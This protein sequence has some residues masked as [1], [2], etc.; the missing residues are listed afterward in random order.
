MGLPVA[1]KGVQTSRHSGNNR[2]PEGCS[3][4]PRWE[5]GTLGQKPG[6]CLGEREPHYLGNPETPELTTPT[7]PRPPG[8]GEPLATL[9]ILTQSEG[10]APA[11]GRGKTE[12]LRKES[13][14]L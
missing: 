14:A 5:G 13:H 12:L 4:L 10:G 7:L 9:R 11:V 3:K 8:V 1:G 6:A 2:T